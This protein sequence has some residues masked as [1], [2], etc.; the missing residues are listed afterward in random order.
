MKF[1]K[2]A[3]LIALATIPLLIIGRKKIQEQGIQPEAGDQNDIF[4]QEL[5]AD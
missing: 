1:W 4:E 2:V 3:A 5:S